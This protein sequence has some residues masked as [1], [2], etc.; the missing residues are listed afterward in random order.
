MV[1]YNVT[2]NLC[3]LCDLMT[4]DLGCSVL[5]V[6]ITFCE[7]YFQRILKRMFYFDAINAIY[8]G[9]DI[10]DRLSA[11]FSVDEALYKDSLKEVDDEDVE[12]IIIVKAEMSEKVGETS[13]TRKCKIFNWPL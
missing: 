12:D 1:C 3:D 6:L 5:G 4:F 10:P 7:P 9:L 11:T 13:Y 2:Y 8:R